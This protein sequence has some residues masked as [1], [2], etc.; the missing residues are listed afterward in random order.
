MPTPVFWLA[1]T[2]RLQVSLRRFVSSGRAKCKDPS[3]YGYHDASRVIGTSAVRWTYATH[4]K[5]MGRVR[6]Y[7]QPRKRPRTDKRWPTRCRCGYRFK[8]TDEW[9]TNG[10]LLYNGAPDGKPC[11]LRDAPVGAMWDADWMGNWYRGPD[12]ICLVVKTPGGDWMVDGE[13]NNCTMPQRENVTPDGKTYRLTKRTHYCWVRHGDPRRP[14]TLHVDKDGVTCA[15]G[16]G[17][18]QAGDYHGFLHHGY[19]T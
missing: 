11:S 7:R 1:P 13:A 3:N 6:Y 18:I 10:E 5:W 12:G 17:S 15:A 8:A 9:Q 14:A 16:A 19:L 4:S 2:K